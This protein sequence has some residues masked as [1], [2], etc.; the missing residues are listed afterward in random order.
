HRREFHADSLSR[1]HMFHDSLSPDLPFLHQKVD[2]RRGAEHRSLLRLNEQPAHTQVLHT[3]RVIPSGIAPKH[4]HALVS[5][6]TRGFPSGIERRDT[7]IGPRAGWDP[8]YAPRANA[9]QLGPHLRT[10]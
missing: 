7:H 3:R 1:F 2:L 9:P 6:N 5:I 10:T 4:P 8:D